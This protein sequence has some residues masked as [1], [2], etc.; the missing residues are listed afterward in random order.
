MFEAVIIF[1][2]ADLLFLSRIEE[3]CNKLSFEFKTVQNVEQLQLALIERQR[4]LVICD[5]VSSKKDLESIAKIAR[6]NDSKVIGYYP[7]VD[8]NTASFA[9]LARIDYIVP[10]STFQPKLLSLLSQKHL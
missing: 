7:H 2:I 6:T 4:A 5:L 1:K 3:I 8:R 9:R 10:R